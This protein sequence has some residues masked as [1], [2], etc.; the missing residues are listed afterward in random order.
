M[1][2]EDT[3]ARGIGQL[4][5]AGGFGSLALPCDGG[6]DRVMPLMQPCSIRF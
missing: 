4:V 1:G 6:P 2:V 5:I 3:F